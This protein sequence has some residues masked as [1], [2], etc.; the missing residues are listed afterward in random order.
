MCFFKTN[1]IIE[2]KVLRWQM[3]C[4]PNSQSP[5][6]YGGLQDI[7]DVPGHA[8][9]LCHTD[10]HL[11]V[12][13]FGVSYDEYICRGAIYF[14]KNTIF[15]CDFCRQSPENA[16]F[17]NYLG[18][19]SSTWMMSVVICW[20]LAITLSL[21]HRLSSANCRPMVL[22]NNPSREVCCPV[23]S[24]PSN[25]VQPVQ[26]VQFRP[27]SSSPSSPSSP[28]TGLD[29]GHSKAI[30]AIISRANERSDACIDCRVPNLVPM[31]AMMLA[32]IA[33]CSRDYPKFTPFGRKSNRILFKISQ[34]HEEIITHWRN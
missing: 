7:G 19:L 25:F 29:A 16:C 9:L 34:R 30:N 5:T 33:D 8:R 4:R 24:S 31:S 6:A 26:S 17:T 27:V 13:P 3:S 10:F 22:R 20:L 14:G 18:S 23:S 1:K 32:S 21:W 28:F 11:S 2:Q 15:F 12:V